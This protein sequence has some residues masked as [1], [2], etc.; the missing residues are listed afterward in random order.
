M[1]ADGA[2]KMDINTSQLRKVVPSIPRTVAIARH[3][4][5]GSPYTERETFDAAQPH[6]V[7]F[8]PPGKPTGNGL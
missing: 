7:A 2:G 5:D 4:E 8:S 1:L 3:K 6:A